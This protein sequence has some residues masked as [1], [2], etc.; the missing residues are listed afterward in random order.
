MVHTTPVLDDNS[1]AQETDV[2]L[3]REEQKV[4]DFPDGHPPIVTFGEGKGDVELLDRS[5]PIPLPEGYEVFYEYAES[6]DGKP[7]R[8][9]GIRRTS[10]AKVQDAKDEGLRV[11]D[12]RVM[13]QKALAEMAVRMGNDKATDKMSKTVLIASIKGLEKKG[14]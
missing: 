6:Q 1:V 5:L 9:W 2:Y 10:E 13:T 14:S 4:A 8:R 11:T 12:L 3:T 7:G